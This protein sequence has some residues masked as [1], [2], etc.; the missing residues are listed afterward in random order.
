[1][2]PATPYR[3]VISTSVVVCL[4]LGSG[5]NTASLWADRQKVDGPTVDR[6][7]PQVIDLPDIQLVGAKEVDLVEE[8]LT[9]R[10]MYH[11][12]L[13]ALRDYYAERGYEQKRRWADTELTALLKVQPFRYVLSA[14]VPQESLKPEESI[15]EADLLY[16]KGLALMKKGG[17]GV[18]ALYRQDVMLEALGVFVDLVRRYPGSDKI[19]DAAFYCGE[20]HKEYLKDQEPLAVKWYKRS[21]SWDPSTPHPA[22]FQAAVTYD[23]RMHDRAKALEMYRQVIDSETRNKSNVSFAVAR[24]DQLTRSQPQESITA[25]AAGNAIG[26]PTASLGD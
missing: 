19:D 25:T 26:V 16:E 4:L 12:T 6:Y 2:K 10:A 14:E 7:A 5:C 11:R 22:R 24:V 21:F 15:A 20:I 9:H 18:P 8:V 1:M 3:A 13:R 17:H 23:F